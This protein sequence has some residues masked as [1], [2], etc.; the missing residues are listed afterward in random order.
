MVNMSRSRRR[1][2]AGVGAGALLFV[3][4]PAVFIVKS[5]VLLYDTETG[6]RREVISYEFVPVVAPEVRLFCCSDRVRSTGVSAYL[7]AMEGES[8]DLPKWRLI[9]VQKTGLMGYYGSAPAPRVLSRYA[10]FEQQYRPILSAREYATLLKLSLHSDTLAVGNQ[11]LDYGFLEQLLKG[12]NRARRR[13]ILARKLGPL[14]AELVKRAD[15]AQAPDGQAKRTAG[16]DL[17]R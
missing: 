9:R 14:W 17:E 16:S 13:Q 8:G 12:E 5:H 4:A 3:V 15:R 11:L 2:A 7:V 6:R 10:S 1:L